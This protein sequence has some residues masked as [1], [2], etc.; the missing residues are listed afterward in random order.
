MN[1][2]LAILEMCALNIRV[3]K[4]KPVNI[5][6]GYTMLINPRM[7]RFHSIGRYLIKNYKIK[8]KY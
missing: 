7:V 1:T 5:I 3:L 8:P 4:I 2:E 6:Y